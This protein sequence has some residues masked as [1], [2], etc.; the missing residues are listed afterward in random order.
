MTELATEFHSWIA[1]RA[2]L[3]RHSIEGCT[4]EIPDAE[5]VVLT[6]EK[7][8]AHV[9]FY[10]LDP[11]MPEVIELNIIPVDDPDN[12]TFFLHFE[13]DD[14]DHAK[15]LFG[16]LTDTLAQLS[17]R[18]ATKIL[19]TCTSAMTTTFFARKLQEVAGT[20]SLD[21]EFEATNIG[22]ALEV[23]GDYTA[24]MLAPQVHMRRAEMVERHPDLVVFEIP[25]A[26]FGSYDAGTAMR[27]LLNALSENALAARLEQSSTRIVRKMDNDKR[28]LV[29]SGVYGVKDSVYHY[30]VY[31][32]GEVVLNGQVG[33][34]S[35][36]YR[37]V[38]DILASV[39]IQGFAA[40]DFD[41]VGIAL[42]GRVDNGHMSMINAGF[43]DIDF[44]YL[45]DKYGVP[46]FVDNQRQC[47]RG[48]VLCESGRAREH[49]PAPSAHRLCCGRSGADCGRA[50][51]VGES[52]PCGRAGI[53]CALPWPARG[54]AR[55]GMDQ[56][57]R[58]YALCLN[59]LRQA[60]AAGQT[61]A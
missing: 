60:E 55:E 9:N 27:M 33:K 25:G 1:S 38:K 24:V 36:D 31:D 23:A 8:V 21:F 52:W 41:A 13:M 14:L 61:T 12:P 10:E 18:K 57:G 51:C 7:A 2:M 29:I 56:R 34:R 16:E 35:R 4:V 6:T 19:L 46:V 28:I 58:E 53:L 22:R 26:V 50:P 42:P 37:D 40:E 47:C 11:G 43:A 48:G 3:L 32:H 59:A 5:H 30:R 39:R 20:L 54:D 44:S 45:E 15:Q 17:A 49:S